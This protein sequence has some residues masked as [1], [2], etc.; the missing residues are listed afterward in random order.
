MTSGNRL[1][2]YVSL[3]VSSLYGLFITGY[4]PGDIQLS[5]AV[6]TDTQHI[7]TASDLLI[8][9]ANYCGATYL[10]VVL[11]DLQHVGDD[12][13]PQNDHMSVSVV[14]TC[15]GGKLIDLFFALL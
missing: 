10:V 8:T 2:V 5:A 12:P 4:V 13:L 7:I 6:T 9:D 11:E 15:P 1:C 3:Y 14:I